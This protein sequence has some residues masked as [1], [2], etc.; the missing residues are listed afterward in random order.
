MQCLKCGKDNPNDAAFCNGCG[1]S[2]VAQ[3]PDISKKQG[4]T[5][6][7]IVF[8]VLVVFWFLSHFNSDTTTPSPGET[9]LRS[10]AIP[11]TS[12]HP[13]TTFKGN[14]IKQTETFSIPG[15]EWR[16]NWA[17][18]PS[19]YGDMNFQIYV[20]NSAGSLNAVAANVI[21]KDNDS[22]IIRGRGNYYLQI[23]TAQPYVITVEAKY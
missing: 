23:N 21:G 15:D 3:Q 1:I 9:A 4:R 12:W 5:I 19:K 20:Y 16:I 8:G 18:Q 6:L 11:A 10:T 2:M 13:V 22:T 7:I 17:T 14:G